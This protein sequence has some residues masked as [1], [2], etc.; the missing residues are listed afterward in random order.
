MTHDYADLIGVPFVYNGRDKKKALDCYGLVREIHRRNGIELPDYHTT[1]GDAPTISALMAKGKRLWKPVKPKVGSVI[2]MRI[3]GY[4]WH[5]ATY[6]GDDQFI[7]TSEATGGVCIERLH[8]WEQRIEGYY[9][10]AG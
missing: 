10:Y 3:D 5:V 1:K 8:A 4:Y 7:H 2:L 6:L 9:E